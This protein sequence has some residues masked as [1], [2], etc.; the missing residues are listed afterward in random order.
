MSHDALALLHT[1]ADQCGA[2]F[3]RSTDRGPS[4]QRVGQ[5]SF[6][7][8]ADEAAL[9]L[10]RAAG[11]SVLTEEF[12]FEQGRSDLCVVVDPID[13]ST[14]AS[15]GIPWFATAACTVDDHGVAAAVV[16]NHVS[17]VRWWAERGQGAYCDG[18]R[19]QPSTCTDVADSI[20]ALNGLPPHPLGYR[21]A[22]VLGAA[23]LDLC[24]V[25]GGSLDGYVDCVDEAHGVWDYLA[26]SL[27]CT[28]AG[29]VIVDA[30]G[31]DL[32]V[33]DPAARRTPVAAATAPLLADLVSR[34]RGYADG[35]SGV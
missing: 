28:E 4:G 19:L 30:F 31:R 29:A 21:Q 14:N 32:V 17:G 3:R 16:V 35:P 10:V 33:L 15:R 24:L 26:S 22:R 34:R 20:V 18:T 9:S 27:I 12:G 7:V 23:A 6:D 8:L 2:A 13:G 11:H 1:I 25:A 5:Y